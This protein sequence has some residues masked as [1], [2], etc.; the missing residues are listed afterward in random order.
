MKVLW[1]VNTIFPYPSEVLGFKKN[2]FGG[3][4][5]GLKSSLEKYKDI[6]LAIASIYD[7]RE[8]KKLDDGKTIYYLLPSKNNR[9]YEKSLEHYWVDVCNDF[10]PDVVHMHGTEYVHGLAFLNACP[11]MKVVTSIQ[12]L[13]YLYGDVFLMIIAN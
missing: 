11:D 2:V 6:E 3:W 7:G 12:G 13:V 8:F 4:M 1:I 10:S 5:L 9:K